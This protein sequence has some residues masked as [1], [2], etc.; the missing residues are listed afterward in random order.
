MLRHLLLRDSTYTSQLAFGS[1]NRLLPPSSFAAN[2]SSNTRQ[3][4]FCSMAHVPKDEYD[5]QWF[6]TWHNH[7]QP[8]EVS[9][10]CLRAYK[11]RCVGDALVHPSQPAC[12]RPSCPAMV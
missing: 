8:G 4:H 7:L 11:P 5:K 9:S 1:L 10:M 6:E 2:N 12:M 3:R